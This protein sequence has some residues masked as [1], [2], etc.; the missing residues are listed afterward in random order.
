MINSHVL[1]IFILLSI[2]VVYGEEPI[3][4]EE[5]ISTNFISTPEL[6]LTGSQ[7]TYVKQRS[8]DYEFNFRGENSSL[9]VN[10]LKFDNIKYNE[11]NNHYIGNLR[12]W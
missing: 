5:V 4:T 6:N 11:N 1:L 7:V 12:W 8:G 10:G 2:S 9:Q 3:S